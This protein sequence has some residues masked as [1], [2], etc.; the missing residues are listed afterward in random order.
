MSSVLSGMQII[1]PAGMVCLQT[2]VV[3]MVLAMGTRLPNNGGSHEETGALMYKRY[4]TRNPVITN[5]M[6][7]QRRC[8]ILVDTNRSCC[9]WVH[10]VEF[11]KTILIII[12][13]LLLRLNREYSISSGIQFVAPELR[14]MISPVDSYTLN[15]YVGYICFS[16]T[17]FHLWSARQYYWIFLVM[18]SFNQHICG[19]PQGWSLTSIL[20]CSFHTCRNSCVFQFDLLW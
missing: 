6:H 10:F 18:Y 5:G 13:P 17:Y 11:V 16:F 2:M 7:G 4:W 15:L 1:L 19:T 3:C 8:L 9:K 14:I 20:I 12:K